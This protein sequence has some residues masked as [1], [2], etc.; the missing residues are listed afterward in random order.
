[1]SRA[2]TKERDDAPEPRL[3]VR[4][5][6]PT[7]ITPAGLR[8]LEQ[9]LAETADP[10][11]RARVADVLAAVYAVEP[12]EDRSVVALGA[13]VTL[14]VPGRG[15]QRFTIVGE[16]ETDVAHGRIGAGSPLALALLGARAG[17]AVTW[18]RPA[19]SVDVVVR[20][21]AYDDADNGR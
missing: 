3:T 12:P 9:Q 19:G 5:D 1:M 2:F 14:D 21:I 4:R 18:A 15:E 17:D 10:A 16:D 6:E 8:R 11:E 7:P 13:T 20:Q